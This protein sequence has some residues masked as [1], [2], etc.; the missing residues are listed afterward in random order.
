MTYTLAPG[1]K[2]D[3][4]ETPAVPSREPGKGHLVP[5]RWVC[6]SLSDQVLLGVDVTQCLGGAADRK[7]PL[8]PFSSP[9]T[10]L[11][12]ASDS[13]RALEQ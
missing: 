9:L 11:G 2:T 5:A 12:P 6:W 3:L 10:P 4:P 8:P 7:L 1:A 13:Q